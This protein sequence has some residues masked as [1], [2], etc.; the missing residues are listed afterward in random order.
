MAE[1]AMPL[2]PATNTRLSAR[3][4]GTG[5]PPVILIGRCR[6]ARG[7][8]GNRFQVCGDH[9]GYQRIERDLVAP[10]EPGPGLRRVADQNVDFGRTKVAR[11]DLDQHPARRRVDPLLLRSRSQPL[12]R[13]A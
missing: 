6:P 5:E 10:S 13:D 1:P 7:L 2:W 9:L 4:N 12:D 11:V 8:L 3:S